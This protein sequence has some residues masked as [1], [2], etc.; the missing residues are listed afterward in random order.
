MDKVSKL[1]KLRGPYGSREKAR[2]A[3]RALKAR[4][5]LSDMD[6]HAIGMRGED[7][8]IC[9]WMASEGITVDIKSEYPLR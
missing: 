2:E 1:A 6:I 7:P 5:C 9:E 4:G 8:D 3:V